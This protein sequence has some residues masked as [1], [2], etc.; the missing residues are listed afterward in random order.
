MKHVT[1]ITL[2]ALIQANANHLCDL[3]HKHY[4]QAI[5]ISDS[6]A[7]DALAMGTVDYC[8]IENW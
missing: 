6:A 4:T 7:N 2:I 3:D 1:I 8:D 5:K